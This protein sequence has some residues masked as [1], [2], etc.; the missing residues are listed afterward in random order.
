VSGR[1]GRIVHLDSRSE[2]YQNRRFFMGGTD[3]IRG[4]PEESLIPQDLAEEAKRQS[5]DNPTAVPLPVNPGG[6]AFVTMRGEL[7]FPIF[8]G[9]AGGLFVD[10]GNLWS[11]ADNAFSPF[12]LRY[13]VGAGVRYI[14]PVGALALDYGLN[15]E[16]R[17]YGAIDEP[18]GALHFSVGLF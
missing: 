14:T 10:T 3:T 4:F 2:T 18:S 9:V 13:A 1:I 12:V 11:S 8:G 17:R 5:E 7:R 6:D 15:L 16:P